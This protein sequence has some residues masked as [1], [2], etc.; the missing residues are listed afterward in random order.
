MGFITTAMLFLIPI[1]WLL[2]PPKLIKSLGCGLLTGMAYWRVNTVSFAHGQDFK[3]NNNMPTILG[4]H[5]A[6]LLWLE[7]SKQQQENRIPREYLHVAC[8]VNA[9]YLKQKQK[10]NEDEVKDSNGKRWIWH[11][12]GNRDLNCGTCWDLYTVEKTLITKKD[13]RRCSR[14]CKNNRHLR[15]NFCCCWVM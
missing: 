8:M 5:H 2:F 14:T 10:A 1:H 11:S 3:Y 13:C 4:C 9:V 7:K 15:N 12:S 6:L